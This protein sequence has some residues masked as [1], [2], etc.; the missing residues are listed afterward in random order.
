MKYIIIK[1]VALFCCLG[2]MLSCSEDDEV[3]S[4]LSSEAEI[5]TSFTVTSK[6][7]K[8][9]NSNIG[10]DT[11]TLKVSPYLDAKTELS[12]VTP[13]FFLSRGATV[14]PDPSDPQDFSQEDGVKY[15]VTSQD[16]K[17][18]HEYTVV[19]GPSDILPYG[20]GFSYAEVGTEK[21]FVQLGYPGQ[22]NNWSLTEEQYGDLIMYLAYCGNDLVMLSRAY[23]KLD[24]ASKY[25]LRAFNKTTLEDDGTLNLGSINMTNLQLITSDYHGHCVA[26][27][28][29]GGNTSFYYWSKITDAPTLVGTIAVN[30]APSSDGSNNFQVAGDITG[31]AWITSLA[32]RDAK[33]TH[34]RV[35]V[36]SGK[37]ASTY[38]TIQTGYRSDDCNGWQMISPLDDSDKPS[39]VIGD[40]EGGANTANS[41]KC[42]INNFGGMTTTVMPGLWQNILQTWWVGT[43]FALAR[44]GGHTPVV[45]ALPINGKTYVALTSGTSWFHAAAVLNTDLKTLAHPNL[46]IAQSVNRTWSYGEMIDWYW[47]DNEKCAYLAVWF[48]RIGVKTYKLTCYE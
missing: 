20:S 21:N 29:N 34:F 42:Y 39:Y 25:C 15:T 7:G 3:N 8:V 38:S 36:E 35:Q 16:G 28:V 43:G 9:F 27:V 17:H 2:L 40:T 45:S 23:V 32:P 19:Y 11:I 1:S 22:L 37:L 13:K 44:G 30:M 18:K 41:V 26:M 48:G 33:G 12:D 24:P 5:V 10:Q 6:S 14:T 4:S 46:N 47:D 31:N